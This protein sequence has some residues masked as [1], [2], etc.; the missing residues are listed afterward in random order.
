MRRR[1]NPYAGADAR[2]R[3]AKAA[4]FPARSVYKLEEIDRRLRI[5]R[6]GQHVLDLGAAPGS[7]TLYASGRVGG[8]GHVLAVD[9]QQ[10]SQS[11]APNVTVLQADALTLEHAELHR[12]APYDVVLSDMA[13]ATSGSKLRDQSL[14]EE[15]FQRA[16]QIAL[17]VGA[18]GSSFVGKLL[19]GPAFQAAKQA[20]DQHYQR[21]AVIRP[22]GTRPH[23]SEVFIAG[24]G[25][26]AGRR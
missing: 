25:L 17:S 13:P 20:V 11:F 16:L 15:L 8:H 19:M 12:L 22:Q 5:L 24:T 1:K 14:S 9:L 10:I 26:R 4:G 21:C 6:P 18:A 23:S 2:T 3:Q 7:W